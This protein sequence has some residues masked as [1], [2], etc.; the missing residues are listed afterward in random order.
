M[1]LGGGR[2]D[3]APRSELFDAPRS[4]RF[5]FLVW[6]FSEPVDDPQLPHVVPTERVRVS[7]VRH[8]DRVRVRGGDGDDANPTKRAA[9]FSR[10]V[11]RREGVSRRE[12]RFRRMNRLSGRLRRRRGGVPQSSVVVSPPREHLAV[13]AQR[14]GVVFSRGDGDD[15]ATRA[16]SEIRNPG[17]SRRR[18]VAAVRSL[19]VHAQS[20]APAVA[21]R[22]Q[23]TV[24]GGGE[25]VKLG[26]GEGHHS[27]A[28][29]L[30]G[31]ASGEGGERQIVQSTRANHVV[32]SAVAQLVVGAAAPTVQVARRKGR[33]KRVRDDRLARR[34]GRELRSGRS[35]TRAGRAEASSAR[36]ESRGEDVDGSSSGVVERGGEGRASLEEGGGDA[37]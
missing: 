34:G 14:D 36:E 21:P 31:I 6:R 3:D 30:L 26:G 9:Y 1:S 35:G 27:A 17:G 29:V 16:R 33:R 32:A 18:S 20:S 23:R 22:E 24:R 15:E 12:R 13:V 5:A 7:S 10:R 28:G 11:L 8:H 25:A 2:G 37:E 19:V 4:E